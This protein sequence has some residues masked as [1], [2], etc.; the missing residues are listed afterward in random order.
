MS[1]FAGR[2]RPELQ[3]RRLNGGQPFKKRGRSAYVSIE[4]PGKAD[5]PVYTTTNLD[6]KFEFSGLSPQKYLLK[7]SYLSYRNIQKT[8][9]VKE[10]ITDVGAIIL[11]EAAQDLK[12][13]QVVGQIQQSQMKG[14]T[15]QFNAAA[16]K[17]TPTP[18]WR[19]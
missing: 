5:K 6:G 12:E 17:P 7:V 2:H 15:T 3:N 1:G 16:S 11:T 4:I 9:E 13:V 14:D 10:S 19:I 18:T 8:V